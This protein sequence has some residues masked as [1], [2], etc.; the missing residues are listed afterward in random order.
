MLLMDLH[1]LQACAKGIEL[2]TKDYAKSIHSVRLWVHC[3]ASRIQWRPH[4]DEKYVWVKLRQ[5]QTFYA[6]KYRCRGGP[7]VQT[8]SRLLEVPLVATFG[9]ARCPVPMGS[10]VRVS[11]ADLKNCRQPC[12]DAR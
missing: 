3:F 4:D 2:S 10:S 6:L 8:K 5:S 9:A 1:G 7:K 11:Q 12:Q